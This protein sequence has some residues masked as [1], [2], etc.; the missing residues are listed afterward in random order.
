M[1]KNKNMGKGP[2]RSEPPPLPVCLPP[3]RATGLF[4]PARYNHIPLTAQQVTPCQ[5]S[6][7]NRPDEP[8][9]SN[10][11]YRSIMGHTVAVPGGLPGGVADDYTLVTDERWDRF[12]V[13]ID[14]PGNAILLP[15]KA[16]IARWQGIF[17]LPPRWRGPSW[18]PAIAAIPGWNHPNNTNTRFPITPLPANQV[19]QFRHG[20]P[21]YANNVADR[22]EYSTWHGRLRDAVVEFSDDLE[23]RYV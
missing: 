9:R 7:A 17:P 20:A 21:L 16:E 22:E 19:Y 3:S 23:V 6:P 18:T 14:I 4:S 2:R 10:P 12:K 5:S 8:Q 11:R 1:L 13:G 15:C